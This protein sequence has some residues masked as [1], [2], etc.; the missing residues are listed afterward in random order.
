MNTILNKNLIRK[1]ISGDLWRSKISSKV[2]RN[3]P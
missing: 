3:R 1:V 2:T